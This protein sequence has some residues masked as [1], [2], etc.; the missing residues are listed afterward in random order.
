MCNIRECHLPH[1]IGYTK[2]TLHRHLHDCNW[3][4]NQINW[5][6]SAMRIAGATG[7]KGERGQ[8]CF[9][10]WEWQR[11]GTI[12]ELAI[13]Q[14]AAVSATCCGCRCEMSTVF[15]TVK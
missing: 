4:K 5:P 15:L 9:H 12:G 14:T 10:I 7:S 11:H 3:G 8:R 13:R 1:L 6:A 2:L